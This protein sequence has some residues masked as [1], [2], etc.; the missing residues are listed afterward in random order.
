MIRSSNGLELS[1]CYPIIADYLS[2]EELSEV[3]KG[4]DPYQ[5]LFRKTAF[6]TWS[7]QLSETTAQ[8]LYKIL[9]EYRKVQ[10]IP[11]ERF[12][13]S[14][15]LSCVT[16][17]GK[18]TQNLPLLSTLGKT[19]PRSIRV[20]TKYRNIPKMNMETLF[21]LFPNSKTLYLENHIDRKTNVF[22]RESRLIDTS[23]NKITL[24]CCNIVE[25]TVERFPWTL[26]SLSVTHCDITVEAILRLGR[27]HIEYLKLYCCNLT[28]EHLEALQSLKSVTDLNIEGNSL[29]YQSIKKLLENSRI[30]SV[31]LNDEIFLVNYEELIKDF[32]HVLFYSSEK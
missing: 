21:Q 5:T 31:A 30:Q 4:T 13:A 25:Q 24:S 12:S 18:D 26:G 16:F 17:S 15:P 3:I 6:V 1:F 29:S 28:S 32:E 8:D 10:K 23:F 2:F 19:R 7:K 9:R 14:F 11:F 22:A 20:I 27:L